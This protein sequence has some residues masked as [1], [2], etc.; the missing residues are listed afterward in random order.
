MRSG[1]FDQLFASIPLAKCHKL[2]AWGS[3]PLLPLSLIYRYELNIPVMTMP[4]VRGTGGLYLSV[5][6]PVRLFLVASLHVSVY[7][8]LFLYV[9]VY[10]PTFPVVSFYA[11]IC[12]HLFLSSCASGSVCP[13]PIPY[14][15]PSVCLLRTIPLSLTIVSHL[16]EFATLRTTKIF[17]SRTGARSRW[18]PLHRNINLQCKNAIFFDSDHI[19]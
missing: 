19:I 3:E 8:P 6:L 2:R 13:F 9:T 14:F 1:F 7:P 15:L 10:A 16:C 11:S 12:V 4:P 5:S 17:Y 18:E